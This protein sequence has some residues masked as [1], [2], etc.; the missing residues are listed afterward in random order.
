M[1]TPVTKQRLRN[2]LTYSWWKYALLLIVAILGWNLIYTVTRYRV[3]EEKKVIMNLYVYADQEGL[4]A[5][6]AEVNA[7]LMPEMEEMG[8]VYTALDDLYGEMIFT[9]HVTIAEGD[10]FLLSRSHFQ[11]Y[12]STG[13]FLA[14]ETDEELM[15]TL[16]GVS[17]TQGWRALAENGEQHLF[18]IPCANLPGMAAYVY[19]PS[20]CFLTVLSNNQNDEYV[21][22]FLNIFVSD[23]L[24]EVI[25]EADA[26]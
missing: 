23:M 15:T 1:K 17:V 22:Q 9:T 2:H 8:T 7:T 16:E 4:N 14:L 3:P 24:E 20:D 10:I 26:A 12:A 21:L 11:Q 25:P 5:Y 19:D 6:M 18:G 13:V